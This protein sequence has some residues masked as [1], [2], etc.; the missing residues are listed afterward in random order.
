[1]S[2]AS[3]STGR[4]ARSSACAIPASGWRGPSPGSVQTS[5]SR[6]PGS[7]VSGRDRDDDAGQP[8]RRG[9][10]GDGV[11]HERAAVEQGGHLRPAEAARRAAGEDDAERISALEV[12]GP[13]VAERLV[14]LAHRLRGSPPR[15]RAAGRRSP[16]R[17]WRAM[18]SKTV[19]RIWVACRP[20]GVE[21]LVDQQ[22]HHHELVDR[23]ARDPLDAAPRSARRARRRRGA[24]IA[25][26]H[27][28]ASRPS[29]SRR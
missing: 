26:P 29:G 19:P 10:R 16:R 21:R 18:P 14:A 23:H 3:T 1:M 22:L 25:R 7:V 5:T 2:P 13:A 15:R 12:E 6:S 20:C 8:R 24:S 28:T 9:Q 4:P 11:G 27:S 17:V